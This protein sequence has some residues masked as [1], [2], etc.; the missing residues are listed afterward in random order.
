MVVLLRE[1]IPWPLFRQGLQKRLKSETSD[2]LALW[3]ALWSFSDYGVSILQ[4]KSEIQDVIQL[5]FPAM[6]RTLH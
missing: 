3:L 4:D 6:S 2:W 5:L 1:L